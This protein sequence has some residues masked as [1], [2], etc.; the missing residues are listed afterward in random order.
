MVAPAIIAAAIGG[1][2]SLLGSGLDYKQN[3]DNAKQQEKNRKQTLELIDQTY[4]S[5]RSEVAPAY[6]N[7]QDARQTGLNRNLAL[8]GQTFSPMMENIREGGNMSR[9]A[10]LVGRENSRNAVLGNEVDYGALRNQP[11]T[12]RSSALT[13]LTNPEPVNFQTMESASGAADNFTSF[14]TQSYLAQNPDIAQDYVRLRPA[15]MEGGDPQFATVEGFAKHHYDQYGRQEIEAGLRSP[16]GTQTNDQPAQAFNDNQIEMILMESQR[17]PL[18]G[19]NVN[20]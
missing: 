10:M 1:G 15:L 8:T 17:S 20:R 4:N 6:N 14:D 2:A 3:K 19:N 11:M 5:A 12:D 7:A 16:L 9:D 13:G 18:G